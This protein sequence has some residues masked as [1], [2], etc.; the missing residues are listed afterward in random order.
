MPNRCEGHSFGVALQINAAAL[1][2]HN[3]KESETIQK[4]QQVFIRL[5]AD[6]T[7]AL[8]GVV[9]ERTFCKNRCS[10]LVFGLVEIVADGT[11]GSRSRLSAPREAGSPTD[12]HPPVYPDYAESFTAACTAGAAP[13]S[14]FGIIRDSA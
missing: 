3:P 10:V 4:E 5:I 13:L 12:G 1:I 7:L 9:L 11:V 6:R 2:R 8:I 14:P